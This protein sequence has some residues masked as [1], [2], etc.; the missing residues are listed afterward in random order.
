MHRFD[1]ALFGFNEPRFVR[2]LDDAEQTRAF[3]AWLGESLRGGGFLGLI[4]DLG[5][6]KTTLT[7]GLTASLGGEA[8]SP[9]YT[10]VNEYELTP[11]VYH[12]DLYRLEDVDDLESVGYWDFV[13]DTRAIAIVEWLDQVPQAW[14]GEGTIVELRHQDGSR[15]ASVW[16]TAAEWA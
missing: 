7:Q 11:R 3:G 16:S 13:S 2:S 15:L 14:P 8:S 4:G 9:T 12:F 6:G 10:L 1:P 5:A